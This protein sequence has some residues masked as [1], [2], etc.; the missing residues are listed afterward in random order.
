M[1]RCGR[2]DALVL[3]FDLHLCDD[4]TVT[5][6]PQGC[7]LASSNVEQASCWEQAVYPILHLEQ[8]TVYRSMYR[9]A[10]KSVAVI[11]NV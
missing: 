11:L 3:W 9:I 1:S 8:G 7:Q 10:R 2:L 6:S 4:I 5:T